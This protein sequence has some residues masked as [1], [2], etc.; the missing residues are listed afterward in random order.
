MRRRQ[1][2]K[3]PDSANEI[4]PPVAPTGLAIGKL[5]S[6][7][8]ATATE[9]LV[10]DLSADEPTE[11]LSKGESEALLEQA[12]CAQASPVGR[13]KAA[14]TAAKGAEIR[15]VLKGRN[16]GQGAARGAVLEEARTTGRGAALEEVHAGIATDAHGIAPHAAQVSGFSKHLQHTSHLH[17]HAVH[18][19]YAWPT[20][21]PPLAHMAMLCCR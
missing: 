12:A 11:S 14:G 3:A 4:R 9:P 8:A 2:D 19:F 20:P 16:C 17:L 21:K 1:A 13:G 10:V 5:E 15:A 18:A 6:S 7:Q